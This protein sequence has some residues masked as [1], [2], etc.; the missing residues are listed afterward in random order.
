MKIDVPYLQLPLS[1]VA[2]ALPYE[3]GAP[4]AHH[5]SCWFR[6]VSGGSA[7]VGP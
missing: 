2:D 6:H 7:G 3:V 1:F 4:G 5:G